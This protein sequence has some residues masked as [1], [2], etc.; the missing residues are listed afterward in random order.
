MLARE[1]FDAS[2]EMPA[3]LAVDHLE[4]LIR[5]R[6]AAAVVPEARVR[7]AERFEK[8]E[9]RERSHAARLEAWMHHR[10]DPRGQEAGL[11]LIRALLDDGQ[12]ALALNQARDVL[13]HVSS[14]SARAHALL[15]AAEAAWGRGHHAAA[16]GLLDAARSLR[17]GLGDR[18]KTRLDAFAALFDDYRTIWSWPGAGR[19]QSHVGRFRPDGMYVVVSDRESSSMHRISRAGVESE[20]VLQ[21]PSDGGPACIVK[22]ADMDADGVDELLFITATGRERIERTRRKQ[23]LICYDLRGARP[24]EISRVTIPAAGYDMAV[25]DVDADGD[26]DVLLGQTYMQRG[27]IVIRQEEDGSLTRYSEAELGELSA[28]NDQNSDVRGVV[29]GDV[30]GDGRNELVLCIAAFNV[31]DLQ[32]YTADPTGGFRDIPVVSDPASDRLGGVQA[33]AL[34]GTDEDE[35]SDVFFVL[36][37][38][39]YPTAAK[40]IPS[41]LPQGLHRARWDVSSGHMLTHPVHATARL[42]LE[43]SHPDDGAATNIAGRAVRVQRAPLGSSRLLVQGLTIRGREPTHH[44]LQVYLLDDLDSPPFLRWIP[45]ASLNP[46]CADIDADGVDEFMLLDDEGTMHCLG[47]QES[48]ECHPWRSTATVARRVGAGELTLDIAERLVGL[49]FY[50]LAEKRYQEAYGLLKG[51]SDRRR[52]FEGQI[53]SVAYQGRFD[54][55]VRL[56]DEERAGPVLSS[57]T[58]QLWRAQYLA[59]AQRWSEAAAGFSS[60]VDGGGL[61][62]ADFAAARVMQRALAGWQDLASVALPTSE[63][64]VMTAPG[65]FG[66]ADA[67]KS[68]TIRDV[69]GRQTELH[70][71]EARE[72]DSFRLTFDL[73][74]DKLG[75]GHVAYVGFFRPQTLGHETV[76][77]YLTVTSNSNGYRTVH[78]MREGDGYGHRRIVTG[79]E[80]LVSL[81]ERVTYACTLVWNRVEKRLGIAVRR[82]D[83]GVLVASAQTLVEDAQFSQ[84]T[85]LGVKVYGEEMWGETSFHVGDLLLERPRPALGEDHPRVASVVEE[86]HRRWAH[87][88]REGARTGYVSVAADADQSDEVRAKA[89]VWAAVLDYDLRPGP[90]TLSALLAAA[91]DGE[92]PTSFYR[93]TYGSPGLRR[94]AANGVRNRLVPELRE[95]A[96][97]RRANKRFCA[98]IFTSLRLNESSFND[99]VK[100]LPNRLPSPEVDALRK[101]LDSWM[102]PQR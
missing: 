50:R 45:P 51:A 46:T 72:N 66:L 99:A 67:G 52:A 27:V 15:L 11:S 39:L 82:K 10:G 68:V 21:W 100:A 87:G 34:Y 94:G 57:Q 42:K 37:E 3:T 47:R 96:G 64:W 55:C 13:A 63:A 17:D 85:R 98:T 18:E 81:D 70:L 73:T 1:Q 91:E 49:G 16:R 22:T 19:A 48:S 6:P 58:Q 28:L 26:L 78:V 69:G 30:T 56:L 5:E 33:C 75:F 36:D 89:R 88:D 83:D 93:L 92:G 2:E 31:F 80:T 41:F 25:G 101:A 71:A 76:G 44:W 59:R 43:A 38:K 61:R 12:L 54:D 24:R 7:L 35:R 40:L 74:I 4:S 60:L 77:L 102:N 23:A 32:V 95:N 62:E 20:P 14:T 79:P 8:L 86:A 65:H 90:G 84:P 29:I 9:R 53:S 97:S